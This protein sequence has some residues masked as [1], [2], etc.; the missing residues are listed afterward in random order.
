M[1][2]QNLCTRTPIITVKRSGIRLSNIYQEISGIDK[3]GGGGEYNQ[4]P[5]HKLLAL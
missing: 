5:V 1:E 2:L 4:V 3:K